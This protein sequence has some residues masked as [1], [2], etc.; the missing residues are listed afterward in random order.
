MDE[1]LRSGLT[2]EQLQAFLEKLTEIIQGM[3]CLSFTKLCNSF[4]I[5]TFRNLNTNQQALL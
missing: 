4:F 2:E 3:Y 5:E 1:F